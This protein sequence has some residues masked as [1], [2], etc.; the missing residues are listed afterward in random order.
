LRLFIG[1]D[2]GALANTTFVFLLASARFHDISPTA[3]S[4]I[5]SVDGV[6]RGWPPDRLPDLPSRVRRQGLA[7]ERNDYL[8][9]GG[10]ER[11]LGLRLRTNRKCARSVARGSAS[12]PSTCVEWQSLCCSRHTRDTN[13]ARSTAK[14]AEGAQPGLRQLISV[15]WERVWFRRDRGL[16]LRR[17]ALLAGENLSSQVVRTSGFHSVG[18]TDV[19]ADIAE[20]G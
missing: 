5:C 13:N 7:S 8:S 3:T 17:K 10:N 19:A 9:C 11:R 15:G 16:T 14:R 6:I 2:D 4:A 18:G 12:G 1:S 20:H